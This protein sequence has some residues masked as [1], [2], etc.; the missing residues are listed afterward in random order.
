[1]DH[2]PS[3]PDFTLLVERIK[4]GS[5]DAAHELYLHFIRGIK[6]VVTRQ[7]G[8]DRSDDLAQDVFAAVIGAIRNGELREPE[9]LA[10]FV[11]TVVQRTIASE[12]GHL[13]TQRERSL[14]IDEHRHFVEPNAES[15]LV[16]KEDLALADRVLRSLRSRDREILIRFYLKEQSVEDI[17]REMCLTTTQFRNTKNRAKDKFAQKGGLLRSATRKGET[18]ALLGGSRKMHL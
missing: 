18:A 15:D 9:R 1:M 10:G 12:I 16:H 5:T 11:R 7:L 14:E 3:A 2:A 4:T 17:C 8:P 13:R 6:Y